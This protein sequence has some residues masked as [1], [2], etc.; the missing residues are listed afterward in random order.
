MSKYGL[1]RILSN[2]GNG[3]NHKKKLL[4][5]DVYQYNTLSDGIK[6]VY[7]NSDE[8]IEYGNRGIL[9]PNTVSYFDLFING[10]LQPKVNY[11]I[12][13]GLL[14][15]KTEDV[16][17]K[18]S[19]IIITFVTF[20]DE[21]STKLNSA[22]AEGILPSGHISIGPVTD[23][24]IS[25]QD[26]VHSYLKLEK[27][28]TSG[29]T[30]IPTGHISSWE[31]MLVISNISDIPISNIAVIDNVLLDSILNI[32]NFPPSQGNILIRDKVITWNIDILN[33]GESATASFKVEGFFKADGIR[34]IGRSF[35]TGNSILG[36][37]STDIV[38]GDSIDVSKKLD[39]T[40]AC[41]I[42]S[43][44]FSQY[45][46]KH[47]FG[48]VSVDIGNNHFKNI[49]FKPGFIIENTLMITD[50]ESRQNFKRVRFLLKIP[51]EITDT[52]NN[53]IKGYL[54]NIAKDII[55]FIPKSRDEFLFNIIVETSSKLLS[56]P[57]KLNS[58]LSFP[59]GV[60]III[61]A[62]G[63]VQL[64]IPSF[65]S[66]QEPSTCEDNPCPNIFGNLSIEKFIIAGPLKVSPNVGST[67]TIEIKISNDGHGPIS[68]VIMTDTLLLDDLVNFNVI[69]LTQG[70]ISQ[71]NNQIIWNIGILNSNKTIVMTAK[72]TGS[73]DNKYSNILNSKNY[74][75]NTISDGIKKELT[76]D[77]ELIMYGNYGI[78]DPNEVSFFNLFING[79]LQ[80]KTNYIVEPGLLILTTESIPKEGVPIIL[81][82]LIIKDKND[83]LLRAQTYQYNT[84]ANGEKIYTDTDELTMYGDK[85]ILEPRQ[86]S[87]QNLFV[88]G[89]IQPSINYIV[90]KGILIL[91]VDDAPIKGTPISIQFISLFL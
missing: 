31:F 53:I 19:T 68:N 88:N 85:G 29:P 40:T 49:A 30:A 52:N 82:Y 74:Q 16:P 58:Q 71:Q 87:Y 35:S 15:L 24:D 65:K 2:K 89:V 66:C 72:V 61:K 21:A 90:K 20:K 27:I 60:S 5:A 36:T 34:F 79:V 13:K 18:N 3:F 51:F 4:T 7:T 17:L 64:L 10:V 12:Q 76:N 55:M 38:S 91:E 1:P 37:I 56:S 67:W 42:T 14:I 28:I 75:Y 69:S 83:Q 23:M 45:Q 63:K 26:T 70:T 39:I 86:T 41:I 80:P 9:D 6:K 46:Q 73:F 11:E 33:I 77:D 25:I 62:V 78:P 50:I 44:V 22:T 48:N 8:L 47:C 43:K 54:P 84:Y 32:E 81:E 59:V 57:V